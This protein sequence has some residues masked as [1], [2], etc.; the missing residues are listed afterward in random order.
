L[1]VVSDPVPRACIQHRRPNDVF[2]DRAECHC[3]LPWDCTQ[4]YADG[5]FGGIACQDAGTGPPIR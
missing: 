5:H 4:V 1:A 2:L 3:V